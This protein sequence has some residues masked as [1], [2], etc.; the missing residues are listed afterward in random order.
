MKT[1][2]YY[3][4]KYDEIENMM[5]PME[6]RVHWF[7]DGVYDAGP[8]RNYHIFAIDEHLDR[9]FNSAALLDIRIPKTKEEIKDLLNE[10]VK[11]MDTGDLFVYIQVTRGGGLRN[12]VFPEGPANLWVTLTPQVTG[13]CK[14]PISCITEPDTRFYHCNIKT[15]NL[16]PAVMAAQ[17]AKDAGAQ[18]TILYRK[19]M[20]NRV[21]ECAH[22]NVHIIKDGKFYTAPTDELILPGIGRAHII[23]M[24]KKLGIAV[25][26]TAFDL[27]TLRSADEILVSS[28]SRLCL[29]CTKLDGKPVGGKAPEIYENIRSHIYDEFIEA[30]N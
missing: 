25:S 5:I 21:T 29:R 26:E 15:L 12:H 17:H 22:S 13:D 8:C 18:E 1:L 6:D 20:N 30:T 23:R 16:I 28:S 19:N 24:C 7:G 9:F 2:G 14:A 4:G 10:L 27:D 3:N 11:K